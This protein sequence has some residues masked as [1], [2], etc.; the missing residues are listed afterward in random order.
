M[1]AYSQCGQGEYYSD[2]PSS[3][4]GAGGFEQM[5][6]STQS[7]AMFRELKYSSSSCSCCP[8]GKYMDEPFHFEPACFTC[9]RGTTTMQLCSTSLDE[10]MPLEPVEPSPTSSPNPPPPPV[11]EPGQ[12][13]DG[14]TCLCCPHDKWNNA[15]GSESCFFCPAGM[16][17]INECSTKETDC[18][19]NAGEFFTG[20]SCQCCD[21]HTYLDKPSRENICKP[22]GADEY[23]SSE[24][25]T[26]C[27]RLNCRAGQFVDNHECHPC[28]TNTFST[29][30]NAMMCTPC[31]SGTYNTGTG[32]TGCNPMPSASSTPAPA[33]SASSTNTATHTAQSTPSTTNTATHTAQSTPSTTNTATHTA[34]STP[35]TTNTAT[36]T[37]QSTPSTTNTAT[38]TA[39][40]TT[41]NTPTQTPSN[42]M[43]S[44]PSNTPSQ[45][46][47]QTPSNTPTQT[48][49]NTPSQTMTPTPSHTS[50]QTP[51]QTASNTPSQTPSHT[52]SNT[53][54]HT[55]SNTAS[56]TPSNTASQTMTPTPSQTAS[57]TASQTMTPTP[58]NTPSHTASQTPTPMHTPCPVGMYGIWHTD[59]EN[60]CFICP[61]G[62]YSDRPNADA[63]TPCGIGNICPTSGMS[64]P[65]PIQEGNT[66]VR[67]QDYTQCT[68]EIICDRGNYCTGG[69]ETLCPA[70]TFN[71]EFGKTSCDD[72]CEAGY[73]C[74]VGSYMDQ[75]EDCGYGTHPEQYYCPPGTPTRLLAINTTTDGVRGMYTVSVGDSVLNVK[76]RV[77]VFECPIEKVCIFGRI[78]EDIV[79]NDP[80]C[81]EVSCGFSSVGGL[82]N[83]PITLT[84]ESQ[85]GQ[86]TADTH[87]TDL[88]QYVSNSCPNSVVPYISQ[89]DNVFSKYSLPVHEN[90]TH[91]A[92]SVSIVTST[93]V[94]MR[95]FVI[96]TDL[97]RN[98][99]PTVFLQYTTV[100]PFD[101]GVCWIQ[102]NEKATGGCILCSANNY[103]IPLSTCDHDFIQV[104]AGDTHVCGLTFHNEIHCYG[105]S[106]YNGET[107][108]AGFTFTNV[109]GSNQYRFQQVE[110]TDRTTCGLLLSGY[111]MCWT[112]DMI[113]HHSDTELL[114]ETPYIKIS[115]SDSGICGI[116]KETQNIICTGGS[117]ASRTPSN[118]VVSDVQ[119]LNDITCVIEAS[120]MRPVC[121]GPEFGSSYYEYPEAYGSFVAT[122]PANHGVLFITSGTFFLKRSGNLEDY[123]IPL[124]V[125]FDQAIREVQISNN[126]IVAVTMDNQLILYAE[127]T[128][129]S[130]S[131][132]SVQLFG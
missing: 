80:K 46:S 120:N 15:Y 13:L 8:R 104:S 57:N 103:G 45:T 6:S 34:Q 26:S 79:V 114:Y 51:S 31:S 105:G 118:L 110:A 69:V 86:N 33:P 131:M 42:T 4:G 14:N 21:I 39:V 63:C 53:A 61:P 117:Y 83:E 123:G 32:N 85:T 36:H 5:R 129:F 92:G 119:T 17:T 11:C 121:W 41:S 84:W 27:L 40:P 112:W 89:V 38:H 77:R 128:S 37:A 65:T 107:S 101:G 130:S 55:A 100:A 78:L 23:T 132:G 47:T 111:V 95:K 58:S 52:P 127:D 71:R 50:S 7:G 59:K 56:Q 70:G 90:C 29:T 64:K 30:Q 9:P 74:P 10:C 113:E 18:L 106:G 122:R 1:I 81:T 75:V 67:S 22:C 66:C 3:G 72:L 96:F 94:T 109:D 115:I 48:S 35:S 28:P 49:S 62:T 126:V 44:T 76:N 43:T 16:I 73:F 124:R 98:N 2:S 68:Q 19:C 97:R 93:G 88:V 12:Y 20:S 91:V 108:S 116:H 25:S 82:V 99:Y 102:Y 125:T 87:V 24:C 60:E 54:S